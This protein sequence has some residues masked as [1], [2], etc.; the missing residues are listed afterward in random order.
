[1]KNIIIGA[2]FGL[3]ATTAM[4]D[5]MGHL[6]TTAQAEIDDTILT[7]S[8]VAENTSMSEGLLV[9][10]DGNMPDNMSGISDTE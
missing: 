3:F 5:C 6:P 9:Q 2:A 4:A 10:K 1:M 8:I 7:A